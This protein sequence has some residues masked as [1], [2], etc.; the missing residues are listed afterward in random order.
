[1][2]ANNCTKINKI[3]LTF[4][5]HKVIFPH[6]SCTT[7]IEIEIDY[8]Q[9][10]PKRPSS[11]IQVFN[12]TRFKMYTFIL[13]ICIVDRF[14]GRIKVNLSAHNLQRDVLLSSIQINMKCIH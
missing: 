5:K 7:L 11:C 1:M 10:C 13:K 8:L 9:L 2:N 12:C 6:E 4:I 3:T 14:S